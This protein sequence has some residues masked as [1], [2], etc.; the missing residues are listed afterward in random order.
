MFFPSGFT[1]DLEA[2]PDAGFAFNNWTGPVANPNNASTHV[3]V[4]APTTVTANFVVS[5][6]VTLSG[7]IASKSGPQNTRIWTI[8][9][10][11]S[12]SGGAAGAQLNSITLTQSFGTACTP[13]I[14]TPF[15]LV[16]GVIA[17]GSSV[18]GNITFDFT[19]CPF[20]ARFTLD[21]PFSANGGAA[22]GSIVRYN[23]FQ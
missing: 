17:P 15:P 22:T 6:G 3:T 12:G 23:E 14:T 18:S 8:K 20:N 10:A 7:R 1:V 19:G 2:S 21:I 5:G 9:I 13:V 4:N 16:L 11:N